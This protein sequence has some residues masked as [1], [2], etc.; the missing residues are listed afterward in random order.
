MIDRI[1]RKIISWNLDHY[2][3]TVFIVCLVLSFIITW[4]L[5]SILDMT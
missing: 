4:V 5:C 3:I 2:L 1:K